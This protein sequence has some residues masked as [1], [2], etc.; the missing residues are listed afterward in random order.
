MKKNILIID[1]KPENL[2]RARKQLGSIC[3]LTTAKN[4]LAARTLL[5]IY[6]YDAVFTDIM[7]PGEVQGISPKNPHIGEDTPYGLVIALIAINKG[8]PVSLV[9]DLNH[10]H[11]RPI[12]SA[13]DSILTDDKPVN[14]IQTGEQKNWMEAYKY[15]FGEPQETVEEEQRARKATLLVIKHESMLSA[16]YLDQLSADLGVELKF[17]DPNTNRK[18]II[19]TISTGACTHILHYMEMHPD[20][21]KFHDKDRYDLIQGLASPEQKVVT[22]GYVPFDGEDYLRLPFSRESLKEALGLS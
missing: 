1:D 4:F 12:S 11:G 3:T 19:E 17:A 7:L 8:I 21:G 15:W 6:T 2:I 5:S 16:D 20:A 10:H 22:T 9:S 13:I 18:E 14:R